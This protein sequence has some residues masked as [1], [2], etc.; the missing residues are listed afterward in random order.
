MLVMSK[1]EEFDFLELES[2]DESHWR[3]FLIKEIFDVQ[4]KQDLTNSRVISLEKFKIF[5]MGVVATLVVVVIPVAYE[6]LV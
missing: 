2:M 3:K 5:T 4:D 1:R 6:V